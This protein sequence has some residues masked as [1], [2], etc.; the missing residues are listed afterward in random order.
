MYKQLGTAHQQDI[1]SPE[2]INSLSNERIEEIGCGFFHS[3][4]I[5]SDE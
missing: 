1:A 4:A 5:G 3:A 2:L